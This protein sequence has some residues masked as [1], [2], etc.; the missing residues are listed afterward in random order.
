MAHTELAPSLPILT[1]AT[2]DA[3][4]SPSTNN[5]VNRVISSIAEA[6]QTLAQANSSSQGL[7]A[8]ALDLARKITGTEH[9]AQVSEY[10]NLVSLRTRAVA[11]ISSSDTTNLVPLEMKKF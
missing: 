7:I 11:Q 5:A 6:R 3:V 10:A 2:H 1:P 4:F 9:S 8:W